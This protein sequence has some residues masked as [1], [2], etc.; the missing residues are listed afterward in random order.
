M[1]EA[2]MVGRRV[3]AGDQTAWTVRQLRD[4]LNGMLPEDESKDPVL[5]IPVQ[6]TCAVEQLDASGTCGYS[7]DVRQNPVDYEGNFWSYTY[8]SQ[9][10]RVKVCVPAR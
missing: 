3:L 5:D 4:I 10:E 6:V 2:K 7:V 1:A 8:N 9:G